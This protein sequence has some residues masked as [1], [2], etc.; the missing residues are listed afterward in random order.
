MFYY[1]NY[2]SFEIRQKLHRLSNYSIEDF[3]D[4][5]SKF[6]LII[7]SEEHFN[8]GGL[9]YLISV[10]AS[11]SFLKMKSKKAAVTVTPNENGSKL[12]ITSSNC[13]PFYLFLVSIGVEVTLFITLLLLAESIFSYLNSFGSTAANIYRISLLFTFS[14]L[15]FFSIA[16]YKMNRRSGTYLQGMITRELG[17]ISPFAYFATKVKQQNEG[18][19]K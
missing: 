10:R 11:Y 12:E 2:S 5:K 7:D 16:F 15:I 8:D 13:A 6:C 17:F 9:K 3:S 18:K 19:L 14:L 4:K 1:S